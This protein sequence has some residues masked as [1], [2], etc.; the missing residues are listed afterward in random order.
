MA[1]YLITNYNQSNCFEHLRAIE[2]PG[3]T[4]RV[5]ISNS[6]V[7]NKGLSSAQSG[8]NMIVDIGNITSYNKANQII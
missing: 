5:S 6:T 8:P 3:L 7:W 4:G 2:I 1:Q